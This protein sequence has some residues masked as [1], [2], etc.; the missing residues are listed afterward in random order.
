MVLYSQLIIIVQSSTNWIQEAAS[1]L[2]PSYDKNTWRNIACQ[3]KAAGFHY[4]IIGQLKTWDVVT[5]DRKL[6]E[7][8]EGLQQAND[9]QAPSLILLSSFTYVLPL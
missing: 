3:N 5:I 1:P 4:S 2:L 8:S 6:T 9:I 7:L